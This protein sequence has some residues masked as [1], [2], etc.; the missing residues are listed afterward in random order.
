MNFYSSHLFIP[1]HTPL[2]LISFLL[3]GD[4]KWRSSHHISGNEGMRNRG[5]TINAVFQLYFTL[6]GVNLKRNI[7]NRDMRISEVT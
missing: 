2:V 1:Y 3:F 6:N 4:K 5:I 7:Q